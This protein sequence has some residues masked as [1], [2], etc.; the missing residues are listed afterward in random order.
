MLGFMHGAHTGHS[1][2]HAL[3]FVIH[4]SRAGYRLS[5]LWLM[6]MIFRE[7]YPEMELSLLNSDMS[8]AAEQDAT[9][10]GKKHKKKTKL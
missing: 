5:N 1:H 10:R 8:W 2:P 9:F 4:R 6:T 3:H 7:L